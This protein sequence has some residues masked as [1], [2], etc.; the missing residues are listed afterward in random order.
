LGLTAKRSGGWLERKLSLEVR[1]PNPFERHEDFWRA[2]SQAATIVM[3]VLLFGTFLYV[4]RAVLLPVLCAVV[5]ALTFGPVIRLATARGVPGWVM[6]LAVVLVVI[7]ATNVAAVMLAAPTTDMLKRAPELGAAFKEKLRIFDQPLMAWEQLRATLGLQPG[8]G[9]DFDPSRLLE[10]LVT[11][12]TP[13]AVQFLLQVVLFLGTLFFFILG[14]ATF[15][16][17]A[18]NWFSAR[19]ARL[20][21][22]KILNDI[23]LNLS[24]YLIVV[25]AINLSLG[26]VTVFLTWAMGIPAPLL[27]GA[28]AFTFNYIPYVG[29]S[30]M[31]VLLFV[32][33]L[34]TYPT[35][36]GALMPPAAFI[37][38]TLVEGQFLTPAI[39]GRQVLQVHPLAIFLGIAFWAWMWGPLGAFLATPILIVARVVLD[40]LYP[41]E[42]SELPG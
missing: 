41:R 34:L 10:G 12:V 8:T 31:Y 9:F 15:R 23:E 30:I 38:I 17:S 14:R 26:V 25:T 37:A 6:A 5:V 18:V 24:S 21:T 42:G 22:L 27:W 35:L 2:A 28:L 40:H 11:V 3:C 1:D 4:A 32:A 36:L 16:Q 39:V 19:E 7:A 33:G 20:Q 13:A 29:P